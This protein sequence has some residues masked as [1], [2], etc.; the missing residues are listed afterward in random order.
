MKVKDL[1]N[2][3]R[4]NPESFRSSTLSPT[5]DN[6]AA[7]YHRVGTLSSSLDP[8]PNPN[9]R[10]SICRHKACCARLPPFHPR[11]PSLLPMATDDALHGAQASC[12][13]ECLEVQSSALQPMIPILI[14]F[15]V[16]SRQDYP[17]LN[18]CKGSWMGDARH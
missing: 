17:R 7:L 11:A 6:R 16:Y 18:H 12:L 3:P 5:Q 2:S 13:L 9:S 8:M 1:I 14:L 10:S 4:A 15:E